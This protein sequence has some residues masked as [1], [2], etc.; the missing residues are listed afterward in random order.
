M[1]MQKA[2]RMQRISDSEAE[3]AEEKRGHKIRATSI[4]K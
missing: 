3:K 1:Q 2:Q 4:R